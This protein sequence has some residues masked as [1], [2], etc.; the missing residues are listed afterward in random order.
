MKEIEIKLR[1]PDTVVDLIDKLI[2]KGYYASRA[3]IIRIAVIDM[4]IEKF[5]IDL[6]DLEPDMFEEWEEEEE[7]EEEEEQG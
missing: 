5:D 3:E 4:I 7:K 2:E 1:L 6:D